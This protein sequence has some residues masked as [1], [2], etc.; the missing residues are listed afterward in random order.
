VRALLKSPG[1]V[2]ENGSISQQVVC[3]NYNYIWFAQCTKVAKEYYVLP[4]KEMKKMVK[5]QTVLE[6]NSNSITST[7]NLDDDYD[8][9]DNDSSIKSNFETSFNFVSFIT[10]KVV[11]N[12]TQ[13]FVLPSTPSTHSHKHPMTI[14][15]RRYS[16]SRRISAKFISR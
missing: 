15:L 6:Q 11:S 3:Q 10:L 1:N 14:E 5:V 7:I 8:D 12:T 9:C 16:K 2:D 4:R 13:S